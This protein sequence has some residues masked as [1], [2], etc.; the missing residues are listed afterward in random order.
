MRTTLTLDDDVAVKLKAAAKH[1][2]F[3]TV[4]NEA[5]R[6]G[7]TALEKKRA[8]ARRPYRTRGFNL[9][10]SLVGS[11]DNVEEVLSRVEGERH[12]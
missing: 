2:P 6:A 3:R 7:L 11:L 9:G 10:P 12:P 8:P 4:V 1:R 5:L